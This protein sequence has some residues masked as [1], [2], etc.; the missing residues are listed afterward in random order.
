M[1][2]K[3]KRRP[4]TCGSHLN[5]NRGGDNGTTS[6]QPMKFEQ[7]LTAEFTNFNNLSIKEAHSISKENNFFCSEIFHNIFL[8]F[9]RIDFYNTKIF[10]SRLLKTGTIQSTPCLNRGLSSNI[11]WLR[12]GNCVKFTEEWVI[13]SDKQILVP[14]CS[15]MS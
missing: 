4:N 6:K 12:T 1:L 5:T 11:W 8:C 13:F 3:N 9:F 15:Q 10:V 7:T 2:K 14:K